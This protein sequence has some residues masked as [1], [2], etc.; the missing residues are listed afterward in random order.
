MKTL[1]LSIL[2]A[3][4]ISTSSIAQIAGFNSL[5][6]L[7]GRWVLSVEGGAT[8]TKADFRNSL[9]DYY[10]RVM[11]EY[12]FITR[13]VGIFSLRA[14]TGFGRLNGSGGVSGYYT[15]PD[16]GILTP[17]DEF[18]TPVILV[19]GGFSY[20]FEASKKVFPYI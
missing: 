14:F 16:T 4:A 13:H 19:G 11:G 12:Y 2:V 15:D 18:K 5:H 6:S 1:I 9:F 20:T 17:I 10:A 8:Y 3:G 7:S